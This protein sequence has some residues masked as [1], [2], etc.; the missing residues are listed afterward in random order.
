M[1]NI[2]P[3]RRDVKY[4]DHFES[5]SD[6]PGARKIWFSAPSVF[7]DSRIPGKNSQRF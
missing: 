6:S 2:E 7:V 1:V 5:I 3:Y 4:F